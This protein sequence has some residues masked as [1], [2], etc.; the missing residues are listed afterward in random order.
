[1]LCYND[2]FIM[3]LIWFYFYVIFI[4]CVLCFMWNLF[5]RLVWGKLLEIKVVSKLC[6]ILI[7]R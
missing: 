3:W 1:M 2:N 5:D 6:K 7:D 4:L